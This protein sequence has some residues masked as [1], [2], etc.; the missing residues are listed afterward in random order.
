MDK[1]GKPLGENAAATWFY[2]YGIGGSNVPEC[3][4]EVVAMNVSEFNPALLEQYP[5]HSSFIYVIS[6]SEIKSAKVY[7]NKTAVIESIPSMG[8]TEEDVINAYGSDLNDN[9]INALNTNG[10]VALPSYNLDAETS[11]TVLVLATSSPL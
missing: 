11:Y 1:D 2:F 5:E 3:E 10:K 8:L 6:G 7:V 9:L 4:L